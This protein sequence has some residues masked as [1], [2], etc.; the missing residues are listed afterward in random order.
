[1]EEIRCIGCGSVIQ[2]ENPKDPG[3]VPQSKVS[4]EDIV[5]RR[6]FRLKNYNEITPLSI[7]KEDYFNI[8]SE[9]GN[10]NSLIVKV[11]D[12]FDIEGSLIPQIAKLTNFND[13]VIIANKVDLLPKSVKESKLLHH[14]RKIIADNNLKPLKIFLMSAKKNK[15]LDEIIEEIEEL[16]DGRDIYVV[17]ATNVGKSTFIN[18]LLKSY[19][20]TKEDIITVSSNA[21]TT[22]D[23]IKIPFGE[24]SIIDTPGLIN[25]NQITHYISTKTL[26]AVTPKKE[27]K[28][29]SFQLESGQTLYVGA[30]ARIDFIKGEKGSFI[31]YFSEFLNVHRTKLENADFLYETSLGNVLAPPFKDEDAF[32]LK[33]HNFTI[34]K[35]KKYDIVLPG[36]GFIT[37][38]GDMKIAVHTSVHSVP[39]V[40]EALI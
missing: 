21:G 36:L 10:S 23:L 39:Y 18:A 29:K 6:C 32:P 16:S 40:R 8:I 38:K 28:P 25:E 9:I 12:I 34:V 33:K 14:L 35:G 22:L 2:S 37:V 30:L 11:I 3:Y 20:G 5:C 17:G 15:N 27:I 26:R 13:L 4:N 24:H 19:A 31:C 7:T 1:M